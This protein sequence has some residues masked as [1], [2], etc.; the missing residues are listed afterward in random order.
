MRNLRRDHSAGAGAQRLRARFFLAGGAVLLLLLTPPLSQSLD[1][2][3]FADHRTL[4]GIANAVDVLTNL[5]FVLVGLVGLRLLQKIAPAADS[6]LAGMYRVFMAG[7]ILVGVGSGWYHLHPDNDSLFWDRLPMAACFASF[8]SLVV[9]ERVGETAGL[10]LCAWLMPLALASVQYWRWLD[11]LRPYLLIQFGPL[12]VMPFV[13]LFRRGP[14][15]LWLWLMLLCYGLA[16]VLEMNDRALFELTAGW[17][18]GHGFKHLMAAAAASM[19]VI[20]LHLVGVTPQDPGPEAGGRVRV[21]AAKN[22]AR[23]RRGH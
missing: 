12:L 4:L 23:S 7:L 9:C 15:T 16:K 18:S 20:K 22:P 21:R 10:R 3:D 8:C 14:G 11:D 6:P 1:Y 5:P 13:L 19:L 17:M 2:H